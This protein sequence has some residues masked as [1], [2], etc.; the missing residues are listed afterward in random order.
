MVSD[1]YKA[2]SSIKVK[3]PCPRSQVSL[4][5]FHCEPTTMFAI[6]GPPGTLLLDAVR[7]HRAGRPSH[8]YAELALTSDD[9]S[10]LLVSLR[11]VNV[12]SPI[13]ILSSSISVKCRLSYNDSAQW[14]PVRTW[15]IVTGFVRRMHL[16]RNK[17]RLS[18]STSNNSSSAKDG[19]ENRASSLQGQWIL[20]K[21]IP[22]GLWSPTLMVDET[23]SRFCTRTR[24]RIFGRTHFIHFFVGSS[25]AV[26]SMSESP[27][28]DADIV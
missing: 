23:K 15:S 2:T 9:A 7:A 10:S 21:F 18:T 25:Y 20:E 12:I 3:S 28:I 14:L 8:E 26:K 17:N 6:S 22:S 24:S 13:T 11:S 5:S 19:R 16:Y 27:L 4:G 1:Q